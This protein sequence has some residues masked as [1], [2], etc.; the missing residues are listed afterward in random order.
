MGLMNKFEYFFSEDQGRY[1]I[2]VN[3]QKL[4][5]AVKLLNE[6]S[7]HYDEFGI[8]G[9]KNIKFDNDLNL[10]V[11]ELQDANKTWLR[12]YMAN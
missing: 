7:V 2:E 5:D 6:N 10:T 9:K 12:N 1:L 11:D 8:I 3:K 4:P